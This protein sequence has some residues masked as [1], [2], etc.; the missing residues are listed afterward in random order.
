[1][2]WMKLMKRMDGVDED[3][4]A[5]AVSEGILSSGNSHMHFCPG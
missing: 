5:L 4:R 3:L 1:M 2:K